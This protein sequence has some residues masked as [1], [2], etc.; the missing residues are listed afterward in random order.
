MEPRMPPWLLDE[1]PKKGSACAILVPV[2][3]AAGCAAPR[4]IHGGGDAKPC[5]RIVCAG[6]R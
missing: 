4:A 1:S 2:M 3:A 5:V 6:D